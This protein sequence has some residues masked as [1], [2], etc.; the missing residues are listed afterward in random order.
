M[1][2][3]QNEEFL[4][5]K[6]ELKK[7]TGRCRDT[8]GK[9]RSGFLKT[10]GHRSDE[11]YFVKACRGVLTSLLM[12]N[13]HFFVVELGKETLTVR[14]R[15]DKGLLI[16]L[17]KFFIPPATLFPNRKP[18]SILGTFSGFPRTVMGPVIDVLET[19][20]LIAGHLS[21]AEE[22]GL[23]DHD[24]LPNQVDS[25]VIANPLAITDTTL[26]VV[27]VNFYMKNL[28]HLD[29]IAAVILEELKEA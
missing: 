3:A 7:S 25:Y 1:N 8:D 15:Y 22:L 13:S 26:G 14:N 27:K 12:C 24:D 23:L 4:F 20:G 28:K 6:D 21:P 10:L 11:S 5:F 19:H 17:T 2:T 29:Q 18:R 16:K 9:I